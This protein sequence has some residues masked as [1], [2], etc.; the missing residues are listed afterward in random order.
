MKKLYFFLSMILLVVSSLIS[1]SVLAQQR[2]ALQNKPGE[3]VEAFRVAYFT[4]QLELSPD[5]A[6]VFWPLFDEYSKIIKLQ[7]Q[8]KKENM[9]LVASK[10]IDNLSDTELNQ[11]IDSRISQAE[12]G[13]KARVH[14]VKELRK[15]LPPRKVIRFYK[16]EEQFKK[17]LLKKAAD[18]RENNPESFDE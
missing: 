5:E 14:F 16:A 6:K 8:A 12:E 18:L 2:R 10:G 4:R 7:H 1:Q 11:L 13:L 15:V 17:M 9:E 3:R